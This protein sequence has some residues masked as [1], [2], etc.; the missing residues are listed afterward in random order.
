LCHDDFA[1][2]DEWRAA[3][4]QARARQRL[5]NEP[6]ATAATQG[7]SLL[8]KLKNFAVDLGAEEFENFR[9][10]MDRLFDPRKNGTSVEGPGNP[11]QCSIKCRGPVPT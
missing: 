11:D 6:P 8:K 2:D 9:E 10:Q 3:M 7:E 4:N 1:Y 5:R